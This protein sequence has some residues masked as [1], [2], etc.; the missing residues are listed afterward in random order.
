MNHTLA[1]LIFSKDRALQ[2][3]ATI[4][5]LLLCCEDTNLANIVVLYTTSSREH[6]KQYQKL[7][8][9]FP[10]INFLQQDNFIEQTISLM[11][12]HEYIL[13]VVDDTIFVKNFKLATV[14]NGLVNHSKSIGFSLR[15][16]VNCTHC[17][18]QKHDQKF[19]SKYRQVEKNI[20]KYDWSLAGGDFGYP[21]E[22]SS[23][24]YRTKDL[25]PIIELGSG[26]EH[27]GHLEGTMSVGRDRLKY[28][29]YLLCFRESVA[30]SNPINIIRPE[31]RNRVG[32]KLEYTV[33][34][35]S[36]QFSSGYR[37]AVEKY[38]H[39]TPTGA[40]QEVNLFL[41]GEK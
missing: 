27:P 38:H 21:L 15:L 37:I 24:V 17:Y 13:F 40:H 20:L 4:E 6:K 9:L 28:L 22:V 5:S 3:R 14:I 30:F 33:L 7:Q 23:S 39:F 29:L 36:K 19:P 26:I 18:A 35:L 34:N 2:L 25:I 16:G 31:K 12:Q 32:H 10:A 41:I 1:T 11:R 8:K